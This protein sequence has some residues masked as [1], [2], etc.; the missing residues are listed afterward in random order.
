MCHLHSLLRMFLIAS[1]VHMFPT[2]WKVVQSLGSL[3]STTKTQSKCTSQTQPT[4][5]MQIKLDNTSQHSKTKAGGVF[6]LCCRYCGGLLLSYCV[7]DTALWMT[8]YCHLPSMFKT[9]V[10]KWFTWGLKF[11]RKSWCLHIH[12]QERHPH[13]SIRG[14]ATSVWLMFVVNPGKS[15]TNGMQSTGPFLTFH[16]CTPL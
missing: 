12:K 2:K 8:M 14:V 13:L 6:L 1:A 10:Q 4:L 15:Y 11:S 16:L 9:S 5:V 7:Q 3:M